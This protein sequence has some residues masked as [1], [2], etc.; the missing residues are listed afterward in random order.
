MP[1][2]LPPEVTS[3][4][5]ALDDALAALPAQDRTDIVNE[6]RGHLQDRIEAGLSP[7]SAL[8][9]FGPA[10]IYAQDF[11]DQY[12]LDTALNSRKVLVMAQTLFSFAGRSIVAFFGLMGALLFGG[13]ALGSAVS[14]VL[15][16]INPAAVGLWVN[17]DTTEVVL[18]TTDMHPGTHEIAGN[19]VYLIFLALI[20]VGGFLGRA[21]LIA[22]I[23]SIRGRRMA[24][25]L[26]I[27]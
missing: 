16:L 13:V 19:W 9:G 12:A 26:A 1:T 18:G 14:I 7:G 6:A 11:V 15:K 25:G 23:K 2:S 24:A 3:W 8:H 5:G 27:A 20:V 22:S 10:R 17:N 21:C 4:L